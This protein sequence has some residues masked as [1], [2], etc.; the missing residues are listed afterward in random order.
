MRVRRGYRRLRG[1]RI[2]SDGKPVSF[3]SF[4]HTL[5]D[6]GVF[7][8]GFQWRNRVGEEVFALFEGTSQHVALLGVVTYRT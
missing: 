6:D 1:P 2:W 8:D 4:V 5:H 3:P 7:L